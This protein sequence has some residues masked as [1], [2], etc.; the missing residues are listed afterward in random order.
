[1]LN[2]LILLIGIFI[3]TIAYLI[4]YFYIVAFANDV[5]KVDAYIRKRKKHPYYALL[6]SLVNKDYEEAKIYLNKLDRI[7][8]NQTKIALTS[9]IQLETNNLKEAEETIHKIKDINVRHHN[10]AVLSIQKGNIEKFEEHKS[11]IKHKGLRYS[12]EAEAAYKEKDFQKAEKLGELA[13]SSSAGLQK[14]VFVKSLEYQ[15][16][17]KDRKAF[18]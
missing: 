15:R 4:Y 8:Y 17:N 10:L 13:I 12:L 16:N 18:F 1:M 5:E 3:S 11:Q 6:L 9:T 2:K 7:F 14:W